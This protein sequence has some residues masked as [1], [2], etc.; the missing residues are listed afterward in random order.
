MKPEAAFKV[1]KEG[2]TDYP[3]TIL[4]GEDWN[5]EFKRSKYIYLGYTIIEL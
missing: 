5:D 3:I 1:Y 2:T 4:K